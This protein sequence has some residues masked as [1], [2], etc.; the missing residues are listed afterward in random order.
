MTSYEDARNYVKRQID[1][2]RAA[3]TRGGCSKTQRSTDA[4]MNHVEYQQRQGDYQQSEVFEPWGGPEGSEPYGEAN[5]F[6]GDGSKCGGRFSRNCDYCGRANHRWRQCNK[7]ST[8]RWYGQEG[9]AR[10]LG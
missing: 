10:A 4:N 2:K 8:D 7:M 6:K 5:G 9:Q 3:W 1:L